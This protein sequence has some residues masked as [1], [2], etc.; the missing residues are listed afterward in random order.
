MSEAR[1]RHERLIRR[2][3]EEDLLYELVRRRL[4]ETQRRWKRHGA[5]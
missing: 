4:D 5:C 2:E 3:A 1:R